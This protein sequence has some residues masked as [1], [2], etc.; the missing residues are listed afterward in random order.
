M[1]VGMDSGKGRQRR[2][3]MTG[4]SGK[5]GDD[6]TRSEPGTPSACLQE[7]KRY[8]DV[9]RAIQRRYSRVREIPGIAHIGG[10]NLRGF[11]PPMCGFTWDT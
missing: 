3:Q 1:S 6:V 8:S 9:S 11:G 7:L 4:N 2:A 5:K 10:R